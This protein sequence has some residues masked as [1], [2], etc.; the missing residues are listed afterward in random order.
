[1]TYSILPYISTGKNFEKEGKKWMNLNER[2][3][4]QYQIPSIP[5]SNYQKAWRGF[6]SA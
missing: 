1:M 4:S 5:R 3:F 2:D 6:A